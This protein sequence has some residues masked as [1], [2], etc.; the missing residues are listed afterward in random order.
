M[1]NIMDKILL[2][3]GVEIGYNYQF[4]DESLETLVF[5]NGTF[6]T[7]R[8][9]NE[10]GDILKQK[11]PY[12]ILTFDMRNQGESTKFTTDFAYSDFVEDVSNLFEALKL[13]QFTLITYSSASTIAIDYILGHPN[14]VNRLILGAPVINPY[15]KFKSQLLSRSSLKMFEIGDLSDVIVLSFGLMYSNRFIEQSKDFFEAIQDQFLQSIDKEVLLPYMKAWDGNEM[16]IAKITTAFSGIP[17]FYIHGEED[18]FNPVYFS[19][20]L[21]SEVPGFQLC[22][23]LGNGHDFLAEDKEGYIRLLQE[24]L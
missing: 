4:V 11:R 16:D 1:E 22:T 23:L 3:N 19:E 13:D 2:S 20:K 10:I 9:W 8:D 18:V 15:G 24:I 14:K 6:N 12:N 21:Q 7:M 17:V 5:M